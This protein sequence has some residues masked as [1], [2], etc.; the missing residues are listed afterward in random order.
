M[1]QITDY[2]RPRDL[3]KI[4]NLSVLAKQVVE[5]FFSGLHR[6]P[7]KGF[8]V[9]FRQHRPYVAG[10]E[11]RHLDWKVFGK[12]DRFFIREYEEET[13]LRATIVLDASASMGFRNVAG[14]SKYHYAVR[15][16]ASLAYLLFQQQD[17]VGLVTFDA[18]VRRYIPPRARPAHLRTLLDELE[19]SQPAGE[20]EL[21]KVL[22]SLAPNLH[23]RSL[24]ILISDCFTSTAELLRALARFRHGRH[25]VIV[26]QLWDRAEI[27]F[28]YSGWTKFESIERP[29]EQQLLDPA[30]VRDTYIKNLT[31]FREELRQGCAREKID[32]VPL[33]TDQPYADALAKYLS[34]RARRA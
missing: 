5:G 33:I 17:A 6:S 25:D 22:T 34:L 16:A 3:Q 18:K 14:Y 29:G 21:S 27:E 9:E 26:F 31:Q 11:I 4:A 24:L 2:L 13:N 30:L 10:D 8:S 20:T 12:T 23:R 19:K 7:H 15:L 32:L 1:A 28:D